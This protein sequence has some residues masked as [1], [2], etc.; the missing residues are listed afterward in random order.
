[1]L[2]PI[3]LLGDL[4]RDGRGVEASHTEAVK[5]YRL[6]ADQGHTA[7]QV[8]LGLMHEKGKGVEQSESEAL[9]WYQL[10]AELGDEFAQTRLAAGQGDAD[11]QNK[12]GDITGMAKVSKKTT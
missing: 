4:Y 12:L 10:A 6:A 3:S 2:K 9:K 7:A 1:M 8:S 11:A 5:W